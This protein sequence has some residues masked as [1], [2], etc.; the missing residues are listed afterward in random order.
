[1]AGRFFLCNRVS[2]AFVGKGPGRCRQPA[3]E[4]CE[5]TARSFPPL[6]LSRGTVPPRS[7]AQGLWVKGHLKNPRGWTSASL[8]LASLFYRAFVWPQKL[9]RLSNLNLPYCSQN[10][11]LGPWKGTPCPGCGGGVRGE[12]PE[13]SVASRG[14]YPA[15]E[16]SAQTVKSQ[17]P[18]PFLGGCSP[19]PVSQGRRTRVVV[20]RAWASIL[21]HFESWECKAREPSDEGL[22]GR[23]LMGA[24]GQGRRGLVSWALGGSASYSSWGC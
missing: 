10:R 15:L 6:A 19:G 24:V 9:I 4:G 8:P 14:V 3:G 1:M 23:S 16:L 7:K 20:I 13:Q 21:V 5:E 22:G 12:M 18:Y 11:G 2:E 17:S